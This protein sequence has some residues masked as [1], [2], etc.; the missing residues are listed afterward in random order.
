MDAQDARRHVIEAGLSNDLQI[1]FYN[2]AEAT[3][4]DGELMF[5]R[6]GSR[7][8]AKSVTCRTYASLVLQ[9]CHLVNIAEIGKVFHPHRIENA[10]QMIRLVLDDAGVKAAH[11][12]RDRLTFWRHLPD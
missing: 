9:L 11:L 4:A 6:G 1:A 2:V 12:A 5:S 8:L 3:A 7:D 10:V